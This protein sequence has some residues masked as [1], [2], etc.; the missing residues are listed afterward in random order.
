[1][2]PAQAHNLNDGGSNPSPATI[3]LINILNDLLKVLSMRFYEIMNE[4]PQKGWLDKHDVE[5]ELIDIDIDGERADVSVAIFD[6]SALFF[7][8]YFDNDAREV[9]ASFGYEYGS[10]SGIHS[11]TDLEGGVTY[12]GYSLDEHAYQTKPEA[13]EMLKDVIRELR[14]PGRQKK[15][16]QTILKYFEHAMGGQQAVDEMFKEYIEETLADEIIE[17]GIESAKNYH[18]EY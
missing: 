3:F 16:L 7:E 14:I 15:N 4:G 11:Q 12:K 10:E 9:D 1:M 13:K 6:D 17:R 2:V 8:V 18:P 5:I